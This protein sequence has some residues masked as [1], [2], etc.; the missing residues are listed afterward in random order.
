MALLVLAALLVISTA[1]TAGAQ[2]P[3]SS[4][5]SGTRIIAQ[6]GDAVVVENDARVSIVRRREVYLRAVFNAMDRWL[7]LLVD[8]A[9]DG[10]VDRTHH[11]TDVEGAW[12]FGERWEGAATIE[13]YSIIGDAPGGLGIVTPDGLV[14]LLTPPQQFRD[15]NAIAVVS[16]KSVGSGGVNGPAFDEA[17]RWFLAELRR[18][19]AIGTPGPS[20]AVRV[21]GGV[22]PPMKIRDVRPAVP[23]DAARLGIRGIVV[24]EVTIDVDGTVKDAQ[25]VRS[26]PALDAAALEAVR[27][28]RYAPTT[29]DGN[30]VPVIMTVTVQFL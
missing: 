11:F 3:T 4:P 19:G 20:G 5:P 22:R 8:H 2:P 15:R 29:I 25:V 9:A 30:T 1:A 6:D 21:G 28:W 12:P 14:Q 18:K 17:E 7:V 27:Q 23:E 16:Y 13:E 10:G 26:I 24:L